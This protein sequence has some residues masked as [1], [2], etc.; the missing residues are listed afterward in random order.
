M[1]AMSDRPAYFLREL[2]SNMLIPSLL[3]IGLILTDEA[4]PVKKRHIDCYSV[5]PKFTYLLHICLYIRSVF[6]DE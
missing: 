5:R 2:I 1:F 6:S 3:S 4:W